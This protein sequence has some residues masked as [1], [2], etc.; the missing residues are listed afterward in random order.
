MRAT[1]FTEVDILR[2]MASQGM[3]YW[4]I[5]SPWHKFSRSNILNVNMSKKVRTNVTIDRM[6]FVEVVICQRMT[7]LPILEYNIRNAIDS[8]TLTKIFGFTNLKC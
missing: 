4:V 1:F 6:I 3:L 2:R 8:K 5:S 7:A